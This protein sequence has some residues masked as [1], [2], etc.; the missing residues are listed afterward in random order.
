MS[1]VVIVG[2][3]LAGLR[4]A[5][6]LRT[7]GFDGEIA[8]VGK[9]TRHLYDR[10]PLSKK[11]LAGEWDADRIRLRKPEEI[12][13]LRVDWHHGTTATHLDIENKVLLTDTGDFTYD[14]CIIATGGAVRR[15]PNQPNHTGIHVLRTINDAE[16]LRDDLAPDKHLVVIGAGFI[17]LEAA[18]TARAKGCTVTV[19]EGLPAPLIRGLGESMGRTVARVHHDNGVEIRCNVRVEEILGG[20]AVSGVR[21]VNEHGAPEVVDADVVLVGIGVAPA[22]DWLGDSGLTIN[23]GIVCDENLQCAPG[24]FAAGDVARW[25]N[26]LFAD[27]EPTMRVEHWTTASEQG[28]HAATNVIA[29]LNGEPLT[30]YSAVPFFWSDQFTSRIQFLG[31]GTNADDVRVVAGNPDEGKFAAAYFGND[32]LIAVL[33]VSLPKAVMPARKL[34]Q[35]RATKSQALAHF[36]EA[37]T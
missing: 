11:F 34:L 9:E 13:A 6:S 31:R 3:S 32:R 28:A 22:T 2:A 37:A 30:P 21:I 14:A 5:E 26:A 19:L 15:L 20:P 18:A 25:P 4:A 10:P 8:V 17:G 35:D 24:V 29:H 27:I 7:H 33:G 12:V 36:A 23:D 16:A 1:R